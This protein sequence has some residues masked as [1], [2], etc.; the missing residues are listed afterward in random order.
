MRFF[1]CFLENISHSQKGRIEKMREE[2][3]GRMSRQQKQYNPILV[4]IKFSAIITASNIL[5]Q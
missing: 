2:E 5:T 4:D 3:G 1:R